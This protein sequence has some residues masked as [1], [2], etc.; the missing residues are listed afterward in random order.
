MNRESNAIYSLFREG[1]L[2]LRAAQ[3][4]LTRSSPASTG[5]ERLFPVG[6][7]EVTPR[8]RRSMSAR[9]CPGIR[10]V[11]RKMLSRLSSL[12]AGRKA[13][14]RSI[15]GIHTPYIRKPVPKK[16]VSDTPGRRPRRKVNCT[17]GAREGPLEGL[18]RGIKTVIHAH[19]F[20][21][22]AMQ[23]PFI[24]AWARKPSFQL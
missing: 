19:G 17:E 5:A 20:D 9:R 14:L 16:P 10:V 4:D 22:F 1:G 21:G 13:F 24:R 3:R 7:G 18:G 11:P 12:S 2:W 6:A 8:Y 15:G 23:N